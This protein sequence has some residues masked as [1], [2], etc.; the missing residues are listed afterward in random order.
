MTKQELEQE[1]RLLFATRLF[2]Q[3]KISSGLAA[4]IAN[5][6]KAEFLCKTM[7]LGLT[8]HMP[9]ADELAEDIAV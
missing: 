2:E 5:I 7:D 6:S 4:E 3:H 9:Q 8:N 1:A